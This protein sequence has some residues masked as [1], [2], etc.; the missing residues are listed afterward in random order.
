MDRTRACRRDG[1]SSL[2]V[3]REPSPKRRRH[4]R[5]ASRIVT[6]VRSRRDRRKPEEIQHLGF[7]P[8]G[9]GEEALADHD[10]DPI[11]G[12][13][14]VQRLELVG[15]VAPGEI[16]V[17]LVAEAVVPRIVQDPLDLP[18]EPLGLTVQRLFEPEGL[19][20]VGPLVVELRVR[21]LDRVA[22]QHDQPNVRQGRRDPLRRQRVEH[23]I[24]AGLAGH[25]RVPGPG[26]RR[27]HPQTRREMPPIPIRAAPKAG[28]EEVHLLLRQCPPDGRV[29]DQILVQRIG[30]ASLSA[31]DHE[32]GQHPPAA[33]RDADR[34][35]AVR[36]R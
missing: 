18:R 10:R 5:V 13:G 17:V 28:V 6:S 1:G 36:D 31:D 20:A 27:A 35:D 19:V 32:G 2:E 30:A 34:L 3:L 14:R 15:V 22:Q 25:R 12:E 29:L 4:L 21:A 9:L 8:L 7:D 11:L 26:L 33:R 23:V 24:R 16:R